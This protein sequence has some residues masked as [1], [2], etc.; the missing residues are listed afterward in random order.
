MKA[1]WILKGIKIVVIAAI[2]L[3]LIGW[4]V[5]FLWNA[6]LPEIFGLPIINFWQAA[7]LLA[8]SRI[9]F[10]NM[11]GGGHWKHH[12]YHYD[13]NGGH[14]SWKRH[15]KAKW[16]AKWANMTPE[17]QQRLR[18]RFRSKC[19]GSPFPPEDNPSSTE[20]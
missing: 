5:M 14:G 4:V 9:F 17:E 8:L 18:E 2:F 20:G 7:G 12:K 13:Y 6:L 11:K 1:F 19:G 3:A 16:E 10:G 15:W